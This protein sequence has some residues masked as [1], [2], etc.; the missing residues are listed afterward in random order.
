MEVEGDRC[1]VKFDSCA[2]YSVVGTEWMQYGA[3]LSKPPPVDNVE[4]IG[5][6]T[7]AVIDIWEFELKTTFNDVIKTKACVVKG[8]DFMQEHGA[9]IDFK[10]HEVRYRSGGHTVVIPFRTCDEG[11]GA[12]TAAVRMAYRT[13]LEGRTVTPVKVAVSAVDG[14][15]GIFVPGSYKGAVMLATTVTTAKDGYALVPTINASVESVK[16]PSKRELGSWIPLSD[17]MT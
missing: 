2:R 4:G 16:I 12:R 11:R 15:R 1:A 5:G 7:L 9:A 3:C 6:I 8:V 17:E 10:K 13:R 14:E